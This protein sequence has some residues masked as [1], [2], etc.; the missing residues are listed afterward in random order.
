MGDTDAHIAAGRFSVL[1]QHLRQQRAELFMEGGGR[2]DQSEPLAQLRFRSLADQSVSRKLNVALRG[3]VL[4]ADELRG[5]EMPVA[6]A[7][8]SGLLKVM[9]RKTAAHLALRRCISNYFRVIRRSTR[10]RN[11]RHQD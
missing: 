5:P 9:C 3:P 1:G 11:P 6:L 2:I 8:A 7:A 4:V 10:Y